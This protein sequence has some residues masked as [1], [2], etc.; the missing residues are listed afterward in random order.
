[1]SVDSHF[2][3]FSDQY[4]I[5]YSRQIMLKQFGI[6]GQQ[7]LSQATAMIIG[8]GG[9]GC[10]ATMYLAAAGLGQII[11]A[12]HDVVEVSNL[13]RQLGYGEADIGCL[14]ADSLYARAKAINPSC[15]VESLT[16]KVTAQ[17]LDR[18]LAKTDIVLDCTD[19]FAT[20]FLINQACVKEKK[21]LVIGAAIRFEG[22]VMCYDP[23]QANSPC[24][25]CLYPDQGQP[26]ATCVDEGVMAPLVGVIG[27][28]QALEAVKWLTG[29]GQSLGS[30]LLVFDGLMVKWREIKTRVDRH[31]PVC[32]QVN[33]P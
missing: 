31:C 17:L 9:L 3:N 23:N 11:I 32:R 25:R 6:T 20:R 24:Y 18:Y 15:Q 12:D 4:L 33:E 27:A 7:A 26:V 29:I 19:N 2:Q 28:M 14:K 1:M 21:P 5:R 22:Q 30:R 16:Q 10:P 13:Q 8:A